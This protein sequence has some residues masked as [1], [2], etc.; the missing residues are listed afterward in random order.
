M[1]LGKRAWWVFL[2]AVVFV[3]C[4]VEA[5]GEGDLLI[6]LTAAGDLGEQENI[7]RKSYYGGYNYYYCV[8]FALIIKPFYSLPYYGVKFCWLLLNSGLYAHLFG[9]LM[10]SSWVG[11]LPKRSR[12][13]FAAGVFLFSF[14]FLH[15][16]LH[17]SQI[18]LLILWC[19]VLG[20]KFIAR[21]RILRGS[22]ALSAGIS[23][24]LLPV[25]LL[26]YLL[27]RKHYAAFAITIALYFTWMFLP[28]L[29]IGHDYNMLLLKDWW[30]IIN[31][32][33]QEHVL[34]VAE[35]S[36]HSLTTLFSTLL[37][38]DVPDMYQ[39]ALKRN[40]MDVSLQTLFVVV[41]CSR[42]I[43]VFLALYFLRW[44]P[45][46]STTDNW[47]ELNAISYILLLV[48]LIF[49]HQQHYA[50]IFA[51]PAFACVLFRILIEYPALT[52]GRRIILITSMSLV[53]LAGN[54][55]TLLGEFN[56]YYE[57]FKI[58]T[59]G[60]LLLVPLLIWSASADLSGAGDQRDV[61]V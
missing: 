31:P 10:R 18:T 53:Y 19:C 33:N 60:A 30:R 29:M 34:D 2:G 6:F 27:Y 46:R 12:Y 23:I 38:A 45:F 20:L 7:F 56:Q 14:R 55:R 40:I 52:K 36:F 50:F 21:G 61:T 44:P 32:A 35:R 3:Y 39:L 24:K 54:L 5:Q 58:L 22:L 59:Y 43:L 17:A 49:P 16:N 48:P 41:M 13:M 42:A 57:H 4:A 25:V 26:P 47:R 11:M 37:V 8:L 51:V 15:E 28:S 9:L 1:S